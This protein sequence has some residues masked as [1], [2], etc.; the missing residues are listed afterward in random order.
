MIRAL[1]KHL[2]IWRS[3]L[4]MNWMES[5]EYRLNFFSRI[6]VEVLWYGTQLSI[7][8][9]LYTHTNSI[10][11]WEIQHIRVFMGTLFLSDC[12][13]MMFF[14][15]NFD[16]FSRLVKKG[17]LDL[18]LTKPVN[19]Q[20]MVSVRKANLVYF[21]NMIL[22]LGYLVWA[23]QRLETPPP[24]FNY[25]KYLF[26]LFWGLWITYSC[27][28]FFAALTLRIHDANSLTYT[29]YQFYRLGTR[30]HA[31]YPSWL[32][33]VVTFVLPVG[34]IASV[35]ASNLLFESDRM[36][37]LSPIVAF[38]FFYLARRAWLWGLRSYSSASS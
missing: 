19:A 16:N 31:L 22:V 27:R 8:E 25:V 23:I 36:L 7:F 28:M 11:G 17:E 14:H 5:L 2:R 21:T 35:P 9:V 37:Y 10:A 15:E 34:L 20:F 32:R 29:W 33:L 24:L 6:V 18:I 13:W 12:I 1:F 3:L 30:P 26:L 38:F 4:K